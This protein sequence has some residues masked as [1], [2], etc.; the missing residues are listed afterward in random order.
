MAVLAGEKVRASSFPL[1]YQGDATAALTLSTTSTDITGATVTFTTSKNNCP[2]VITCCYDMRITATG[3]GYCYGQV[4]V[5][6]VT[7]AKQALFVAQSAETRVA[8]SFTFY[9]TLA[10]SGSHTIK[11]KGKKDSVGTAIIEN[12]SNTGVTV[13]VF[14]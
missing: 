9:T 11:L 1:V 4:A 2:V 10:S 14:G 6:G 12:G 3:T 13:M 7:N 8:Q 5:D